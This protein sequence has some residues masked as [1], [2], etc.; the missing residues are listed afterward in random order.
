MPKN[1]CRW[2]VAL[3]LNLPLTCKTN[4]H[5]DR[6]FAIQWY[7]YPDIN[8]IEGFIVT[9]K[10]AIKGKTYGLKKCADKIVLQIVVAV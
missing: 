9:F 8:N 10:F 6:I 4:V 2:I 1:T 7:L 5:I 3:L